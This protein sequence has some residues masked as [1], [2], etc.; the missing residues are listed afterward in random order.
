MSEVPKS[1]LSPAE[2]QAM[3]FQ[4]EGECLDHMQLDKALGAIDRLRKRYTPNPETTLEARALFV[5]GYAG[6]GKSTLLAQYERNERM[7]PGAF[8]SDEDGDVRP[9]VRLQVPSSAQKRQFVSAIVGA[10]GYKAQA[11]VDSTAIVLEIGDLCRR[12]GVQV[13][14]LDEAHELTKGGGKRV[15]VIQEFVKSLL[16]QTGV[17]FVLAGLPGVLDLQ[18]EEQVGRRMAPVFYLAPYDWGTEEG[19]VEFAT[20]LVELEAKVGVPFVPS[21]LDDPVLQARMY[22]A[23]KGRIGLVSKYMSAALDKV[24]HGELEKITPY[25]LG[26]IFDEFRPKPMP[27]IAPVEFDAPPVAAAVRTVPVAGNPFLVEV[28]E[29][30]RMWNSWLAVGEDGSGDEETEAAPAKPDATKNDYKPRKRE[31]QRKGTFRGPKAADG[32]R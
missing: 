30:R 3:L 24:L 14:L 22:Y 2:H 4:L 32:R 27:A 1:E 10:L 6:A 11:D 13:I 29:F 23:T 12:M 28:D 20:L 26:V 18:P 25:D 5:V 8:R 7:K 17:Q 21:L 31:G 15:E 16:N 19:R 9:V